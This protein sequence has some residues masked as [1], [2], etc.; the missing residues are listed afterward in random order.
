MAIFVPGIPCPVCGKPILAT[1]E[2][3]MFSPFVANE[4]DPMFLFSDGVFHEKCFHWH[5]L[6]ATV[7]FYYHQFTAQNK[8][9]NRKCLVCHE[10]INDPN[11]YLA[12]ACLTSDSSNSLFPYNFARFHRS[13]LNRWPELPNITGILKDQFASGVSKGKGMEWVLRILQE[14]EKTSAAPNL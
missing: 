3:V 6:A 7:E 10:A 1:D 2:K 13:C 11:D 14:A 5:P 4:A 9:A 8:M 12:F